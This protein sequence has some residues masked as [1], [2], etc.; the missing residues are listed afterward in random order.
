MFRLKIGL[1][2]SNENKDQGLVHKPELPS[3]LSTIPAQA[4]QVLYRGFGY[5]SDMA[6]DAANPGDSEPWVPG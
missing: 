5:E 1:T 2:L 6:T 3:I 4:G